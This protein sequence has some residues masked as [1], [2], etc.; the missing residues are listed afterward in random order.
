MFLDFKILLQTIKILFDKVSSSGIDEDEKPTVTREEA[1]EMNIDV[2]GWEGVR[3]DAKKGNVGSLE[4]W[5]TQS[6]AI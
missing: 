2:I 5:L 4:Q 3:V 1:E 6:V